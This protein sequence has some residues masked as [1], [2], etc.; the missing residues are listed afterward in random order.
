LRTD[1]SIQFVVY[2]LV[3]LTDHG[4]Q[5]LSI[6]DRDVASRI[7]NQTCILQSSSRDCHALPPTAQHVCDKLL[8]HWDFG[9]IQS[10]MI[11]EQLSAET[12][13]QWMEAVADSRL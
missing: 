12:L 3:T 11:Q 10:V 5:A 13:L 7:V 6:E 2:N 8:R 4:F 9:A 1:Q